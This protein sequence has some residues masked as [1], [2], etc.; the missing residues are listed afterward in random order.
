[1]TRNDILTD[2]KTPQKR[3]SYRLIA[4]TG[5]IGSGK[6]TA[7]SILTEQGFPVVS[8]D[9]FTRKLYEEHSVKA[10]LKELFPSAVTGTTRLRADK[11]AIASICF[12]DD[13]SYKKLCDALSMPTFAA[14]RKRADALGKSHDLVFM[15]VPLLF[16]YG[17]QSEFDEVLV[18]TRPLNE[19]IESVKKRSGLTE[20]EIRARIARQFDYSAARLSD[21]IVIEN[22]GTKERLKEKLLSALR[23]LCPANN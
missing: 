17:L 15:E 18:I 20:A 19:R 16:E 7:L 2:L 5:G 10:R 22:D 9:E 3:S 6:T 11:K 4:V 8:C 14:A 1:M 12:N 13:E 23:E 21:Y